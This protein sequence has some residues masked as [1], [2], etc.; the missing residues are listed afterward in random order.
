M[1]GDYTAAIQ[2]SGGAILFAVV[3][4]KLSE[5]I[6]FSDDLARGVVM[7]GMPFANMHSPELAERM[8]YVRELAAKHDLTGKSSSMSKAIDAVSRYPPPYRS[9]LF[10][11]ADPP[12]GSFPRSFDLTGPRAVHQSLHE[13]GQSIDRPSSAPSERLCSADPSSIE[14]TLVPRSSSGFP[15]G[16]ATKSQSPTD[17]AAWFSRLLPSSRIERADFLRHCNHI[18]AN[19]VAQ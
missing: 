10:A 11:G 16:F 4:A 6:N 18:F 9:L 1:L 5:G 14:D 17:S 19:L 13:G 7:V 12:F 3:G 15:G 8:K 2:G